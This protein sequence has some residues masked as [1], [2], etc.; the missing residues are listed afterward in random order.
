MEMITSDRHENPHFGEGRQDPSVWF[1]SAGSAF[2][3]DGS[4]GG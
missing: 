1:D 4:R 3:H 2:T